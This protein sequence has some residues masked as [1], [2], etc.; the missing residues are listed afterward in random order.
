[1]IFGAGINPNSL[2]LDSNK[3]TKDEKVTAG[4]ICCRSLGARN[5][6]EMLYFTPSIPSHFFLITVI[7]QVA[8]AVLFIYSFTH[9][10][11]YSFSSTHLLLR[12]QALDK[13][14]P[15]PIGPSG[16]YFMNNNLFLFIYSF[17]YLSG[18]C[19]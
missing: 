16:L 5:C 6:Q 7:I 8:I 14:G 11:I 19:H 1:M 2:N 17:V 4:V 9:L 18:M 15:F 10:F 13:K 12:V 3:K